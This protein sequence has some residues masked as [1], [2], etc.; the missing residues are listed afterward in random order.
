LEHRKIKI[1]AIESNKED[2][3]IDILT[4]AKRHQ[5]MMENEMTGHIM[6]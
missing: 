4:A 5:N 2:K 1:V 3:I 6:Y